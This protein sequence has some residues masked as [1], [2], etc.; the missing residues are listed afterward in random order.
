MRPI[1]LK[2]KNLNSFRTMQEI[3]FAALA[4][5]NVFGIFGNT[6]SGKS[7]IIDGITLAL[8]GAVS[9]AK[10]GK[11]GII[12]QHER[13]MSVE[14]IFSLG[15]DGERRFFGVERSY[16]KP[17]TKGII[18][19]LVVNNVRSRVVEY[20][21]ATLDLN[22][23]T[24]LTEGEKNVTD[25]IIQLLGLKLE[26]FRRAIIL[27]QGAFAEFLQLEPKARRE[28]LER[29]F[30]LENYGKILTDRLT[31]KLNSATA[32]KQRLIGE[33]SGLGDASA[34]KVLLAKKLWQEQSS[35]AAKLKEKVIKLQEEY[36]DNKKYYE[37]NKELIIAQERKKIHE[38]DQHKYIAAQNQL[39]RAYN[40]KDLVPLIR[41][42][43]VLLQEQNRLQTDLVQLQQKQA[44]G[45]KN[46][47]LHEENITRLRAE[48]SAKEEFW[49]QQINILNSLQT[50]EKSLL[51]N[52]DELN[53]CIKKQRNIEKKMLDNNTAI[54]NIDLLLENLH[55]H[56][57][58][59]EHRLMAALLADEL[60]DGQACLVCGATKH[61]K[62]VH[63]I[64]LLDREFDF[65]QLLKELKDFLI[66]D[67]KASTSSKNIGLLTNENSLGA[68]EIAQ[69]EILSKENTDLQK[70]LPEL[71]AQIK[72]L[73][74]NITLE[75]S[76][77]QEFTQGK[78]I[79]VLLQAIHEEKNNLAEQISVQEETLLQSQK[80]YQHF[81]T[82]IAVLKSRLEENNKLVSSKDN[83]ISSK[84][85][86][87][88]FSGIEECV[89][90]F[91]STEN[92]EK[93]EK[94]ITNYKNNM[95]IFEGDIH[96]LLTLIEDKWITVESWE[97][98]VADFT[99]LKNVYEQT[100][101]D[102][103]LSEANYQGLF[104]KQLQWQKIHTELSKITSELD[105][106]EILKKLLR[107]NEFVD[108]LATEQLNIVITNAT[109]RLKQLTNNRYALEL[110]EDKS[111]WIRD[112]HNGGLKRAASSL[113]GGETFQ[114]SLALALALSMQIQLKGKYPLE[115][116]F[117]DEGFGSLDQEVLEIVLSTILDLPSSASLI[118]GLIS[119]V[120]FL[121]DKMP[122]RLIVSGSDGLSIGS[123]VRLEIV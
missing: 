88:D 75:Q 76:K 113:S 49:T 56:K 108:F 26:D 29:L 63:K 100:N 61:E 30:S 41:E 24:V 68:K 110:G 11:Q 37:Y 66:T 119:H 123:T 42:Q 22:F 58:K 81:I 21:D 86:N 36:E 53:K 7:T 9:R 12:N 77:L 105:T 87:T 117:L 83:L 52:S 51:T 72:L 19:P 46:I 118:I 112:D 17:K 32:N 39:C 14:F 69:R 31:N 104:E 13:D 62:K 16:T 38:K 103:H 115:F 55:A 18:N 67:S 70:Q 106:M 80:S 79:S 116:F 10:N 111:F 5:H 50:V 25:F 73:Q 94:N 33:L 64:E 20:I 101:K 102:S 97:K 120:E 6:G 85:Q 45:E 107:G 98:T 84:L 8:Y 47:K 44:L 15:R 43:E 23:A 90:A 92:L 28:M 57:I 95:L 96:R 48:Q 82:N 1:N 34:E 114:T 74:N 71:I 93:L 54:K 59:N 35:Q 65:E 122:R 60:V 121:Q 2:I 27:P 78:K 89:S 91:L 40:A 109:S 3:D 4:T 99:E